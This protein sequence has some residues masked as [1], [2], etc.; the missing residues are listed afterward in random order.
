MNFDDLD[1]KLRLFETAH[2]RAVLPETHIVAR[3]DGRSFTR[4]TKETV[5]F[6]APFDVQFRDMMIETV[7][8]L[9]TS[10]FTVIYGYTQSDEISLLLSINDQSFGRRTRKL[11]SI[12][13]G[14]ASAKFSVVLGQVAAFDCRLSEFPNAGLVIDYFRWRQEDAHRNS[15]NA[16]CYW[17]LR[18]QGQTPTQATR[19][20]E[21]MS[22]A[23]KN[24]FLFQLGI[25]V[26]TLPAWQKRGVG[27]TWKD[28]ERVGLNP[29]TN[30]SVQ[31]IRRQLVVNCELPLGQEYSQ[32]IGSLIDLN[33]TVA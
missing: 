32:F 18:Q 24:E 16:H 29:V 17:R 22:I 9:M 10:G 27:I 4:L 3:I 8:H 14:E 20:I 21:G 26:N 7:Q 1:R 25:N 11:I 19:Q 12:L 31:T 33:A 15:L 30:Q 28:V 13:A 5:G 2:D 6:E 23:A